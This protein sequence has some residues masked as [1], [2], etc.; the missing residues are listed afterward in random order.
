MAWYEQYQQ[1]PQF[2]QGDASPLTV[3][4]DLLRQEIAN[5]PIQSVSGHLHLCVV[6]C[7]DIIWDTNDTTLANAQAWKMPPVATDRASYLKLVSQYGLA[8]EADAAIA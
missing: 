3:F 4:G 5:T 2:M 7:N 8:A 6:R 1:H